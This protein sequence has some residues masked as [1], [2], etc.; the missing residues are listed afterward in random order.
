L[1]EVA[2]IKTVPYV[3]LS[4]PFVALIGT[5]RR[6]YPDRT[7]FWTQRIWSQSYSIFNITVIEDMPDWTD[8]CQNPLLTDQHR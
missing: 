3:P 4:H 7:L 8:A 6:E 2:E 1:L 5:V